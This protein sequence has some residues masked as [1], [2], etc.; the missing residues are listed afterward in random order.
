MYFKRHYLEHS[1]LETDPLPVLLYCIFLA[2]KVENAFVPLQALVDATRSKKMTTQHIL[3][4]EF[5][6]LQSLHYDLIVY[7]PYRPLHGFLQVGC[8]AVG[9]GRC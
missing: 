6:V 1:V 5:R 7:T 4:N 2:G 9:A 8:A 3:D